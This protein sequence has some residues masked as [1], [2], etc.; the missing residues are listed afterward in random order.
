LLAGCA[1]INFL[2]PVRATPNT[3]PELVAYY[4]LNASAAD[5]SG[6][7][8]DGQINGA[9]PATDRFGTANGALFFDGFEN[10]VDLGT[11]PA[12]AFP[13]G[14]TISAWI[15][16]EGTQSGVYFITEARFSPMFGVTTHSYGVHTGGGFVFGTGGSDAGSVLID[17]S[18][19]SDGKW[20]CVTF[21]YDPGVTLEYFIDGALAAAAPVTDVGTFEYGVS[22]R[23]GAAAYMGGMRGDIDDV[24]FY[25]GPLSP[26]EVARH[27]TAEAASPIP[28]IAV[29]PESATI[30]LGQSATFQ[31]IVK[32]F[33]EE[34][35]YQWFQN[36][37]VIAGATNATYTTEPLTVSTNY[38][39]MVS[40]RAGSFGVFSDPAI[41]T[42]LGP[43][44]QEPIAHWTFDDPANLGRDMA[45]NFSGT[46][47]NAVPTSGPIG[48]GAIEFNGSN[49]YMFVGGQNTPLLLS[50]G[51]YTIAWWQ[52]WD[53]PTPHI[54]N[55][56]AMDDGADFSGGYSAWLPSNASSMNIVHNNG[57]LHGWNEVTV[58]N[59]DWAHYTLAYDGN[60]LNLYIGDLLAG[61]L[62]NVPP[63]IQ[64]GDDPFL[65]GAIRLQ[66][67]TVVNFFKGA[68]DDFRIYNRALG[69][70]EIRALISQYGFSISQSGATL[71]L[72]WPAT[73]DAQYRVEASEALGTSASWTPLG[74]TIQSKDNYNFITE[75]LG[76]ARRFYRLKKL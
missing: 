72:R 47:F 73:S 14:F 1:L 27:Y 48:S 40:V 2:L 34:P 67:G 59:T 4:P 20:H 50:G 24:R 29:Q 6:N 17:N 61:T 74:A 62:G 21:V 75:Q 60:S 41:L 19:V 5:A 65:I 12:F 31:V 22:V 43:S 70:A 54:Q 39:F 68:I 64:D 53:G 56:Y 63:L 35:T 10:Y 9:T 38:T 7:G 49:A 52:R 30:V 55:I 32:G 57:A 8:F 76:T 25:N 33:T 42:V 51:A 18:I 71:I 37:D 66:T 58:A 69:V 45:G 28:G 26:A 36:G 23:I 11:R 16:E 46:V 15:K 3:S 13:D 44:A